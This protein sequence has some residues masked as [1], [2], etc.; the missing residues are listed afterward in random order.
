MSDKKGPY[1]P[2]VSATCLLPS[3]YPHVREECQMQ[4]QTVFRRLGVEENSPLVRRAVA[5]NI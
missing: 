2:R 1:S 5:E 3:C 4:L